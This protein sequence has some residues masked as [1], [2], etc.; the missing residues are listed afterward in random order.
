MKFINKILVIVFL[1]GFTN[2]CD[3]LKLDLQE[4]PNAITPE[5]ASLNDLYNSIQ[6]TFA[7]IY[8]NSEDVP[9]VATRMYHLTQ[10]TYVDLGTPTRF[11][12]IWQEAY[13]DLF[14]DVDALLALSEEQGFDIHAGTAKIMKAYVMM[15]LVDLLGDVPFT[16]AGQGIDVIAPNATPGADVYSA[17]IALLDEAI[18]QLTG[19]VAGAPAFDNF[20]GGDPASWITFANTLK[21]RAALNMGDVGTFNSLVSAGDI[22]DDPDEDFQFNFGN[23]RSNPNSRHNRYNNHYESGDGRYLSNYYMWLLREDK[24]DAS[25]LRQISIGHT[26]TSL[27]R[28]RA[29]VQR[30]S[31]ASER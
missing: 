29:G 24:Q 20:Y 23:N 7:A 9:G 14:P 16:E 28:G 13:A 5:K 2:A 26:G 3:N 12:A 21:L 15:V 17:A 19:T 25:W 10:F 30:A 6:L 18:G 4:N 8:G 1:L 27:G 31:T 22:I 11:N